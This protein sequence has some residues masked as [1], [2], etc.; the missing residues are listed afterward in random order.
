MHA[1][2]HHNSCEAPH[3]H[4]L[5]QRCFR[6]ADATVAISAVAAAAA[7]AAADDALG[8]TPACWPP[9]WDENGQ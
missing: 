9:S 7:D 8:G 5:W 3:G 6:S 1:I 2:A 4:H